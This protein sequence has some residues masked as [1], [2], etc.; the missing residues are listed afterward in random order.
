MNK[1]LNFFF[2][3]IVL[4]IYSCDVNDPQNPFKDSEKFLRYEEGNIWIYDYYRY[5]NLEGREKRYYIKTSYD[6]MEEAN[7]INYHRLKNLNSVNGDSSFNLYRID[8]KSGYLYEYS[9]TW[10]QEWLITILTSEVGKYNIDYAKYPEDFLGITISIIDFNRF[11]DSTNV[12]K[13][14]AVTPETQ[15]NYYF[16]DLYGLVDFDATNIGGNTDKKLI[17]CMIN[18]VVYGDTSFS[19]N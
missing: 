16:T 12:F 18:S 7:G 1:F 11:G 15:I 14:Y 17:G 2:L 13:H 19:R 8:Y 9:K 10:E 3:I 4:S 6:G 5:D